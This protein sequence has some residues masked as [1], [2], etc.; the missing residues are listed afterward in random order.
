[1]KQ[2]ADMLVGLGYQNVETYIQSGNVLLR[3]PELNRQVLLK[4]IA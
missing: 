1:M 3:H 2:L 4:Q